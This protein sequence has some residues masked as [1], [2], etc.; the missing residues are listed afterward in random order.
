MKNNNDRFANGIE[1]PVMVFM[2]VVHLLAIAL[3][4]LYPSFEGLVMFLILYLITGLGVTVGYHRKLTHSSFD[5]ANWVN[6]VLAVMG[7]LS[8]EGPPIFWVSLHR[9]HHKFSDQE[10][11]PHSPKDGFWWSHWLWIFPKQ[12]KMKLGSL[13]GK[14]APDLTKVPFYQFLE[15]SYFFWHLG[16]LAIVYG[17]GWYYGTYYKEPANGHFMAMS[18]VAY[19]FFF[20]M[21]W[22]L[23]AT[24]MVNSVS[25]VWGY[26][27]YDTSDDSRNNALVA[28]VAHGEGWHNNHHFTQSA[29]NHGHRWWE[30][31]LSF[32]IILLLA[33]I[34]YPMKWVGLGKYRLA[35]RLRYYSYKEQKLKTWFPRKKDIKA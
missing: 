19:G 21:I 5:S 8:G 29:V 14:W 32:V 17:L 35:Y 15:K 34:S 25:H 28:V 11:D 13:Y 26:K 12:N 23:H 7:L 31:D 20:R 9:K 16:L 30:L 10:G 27:N 22:V 2:V 3:C 4:F 33:I 18:F 24:W 1:W 6:N